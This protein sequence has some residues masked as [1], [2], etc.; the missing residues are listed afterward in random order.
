MMSH[1]A[2]LLHMKNLSY[3]WNVLYCC[4]VVLCIY[5]FILFLLDD[6]DYLIMYML[7]LF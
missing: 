1:D 2:L 3:I 6:D 5:I 4:H 7:L